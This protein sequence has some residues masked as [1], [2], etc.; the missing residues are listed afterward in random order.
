MLRSAPP[1]CSISEIK[2]GREPTGIVCMDLGGAFLHQLI[3]LAG[4]LAGQR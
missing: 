1:N 3:K 2:M 4:E